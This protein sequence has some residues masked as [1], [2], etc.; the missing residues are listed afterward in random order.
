[1]TLAVTGTLDSDRCR[2]SG[3]RRR[4]LAQPLNLN[5]VS[6]LR[7]EFQ[8]LHPSP[9]AVSRLRASSCRI[10][11]PAQPT[12]SAASLRDF[13]SGAYTHE[14]VDEKSNEIPAVQTLI[15]TLGLSGRVFT[16]DAMHCQKNL[17]NR[18]RDRQ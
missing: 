15:A 18:P 7:I 16:L 17:Q 4:P 3:P 10:F 8:L 14:V 2:E 6:N 13:C 1:M 11:T 12:S 5:R 9:F